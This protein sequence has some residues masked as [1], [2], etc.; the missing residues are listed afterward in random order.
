MIAEI[1]IIVGLVTLFIYC[2]PK[3][4]RA[5]QPMWDRITFSPF[6]K[7]NLCPVECSKKFMKND[8]TP[9]IIMTGNCGYKQ[10][11]FIFPCPSTCCENT[12]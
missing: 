3:V 7:P 8:L 10:D 9:S 6:I 2:N 4:K 12:E 1:L 11:A 5:P